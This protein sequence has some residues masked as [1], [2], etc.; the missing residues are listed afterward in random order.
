MET[1]LKQSHSFQQFFECW[2]LAEYHRGTHTFVIF[3]P[4]SLY[5]Y[6]RNKH[7]AFAH[8]WSIIHTSDT[9]ENFPMVSNGFPQ[10]IIVDSI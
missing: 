9:C 1:F 10:I 6:T 8:I 7:Y 2:F 5:I 3:L 4:R